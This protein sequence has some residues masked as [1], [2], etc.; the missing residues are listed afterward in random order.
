MEITLY[1]KKILGGILSG[2]VNPSSIDLD[3]ADMPDF[4]NA[5]RIC[6]E[7]DVVSPDL[8]AMKLVE[9]YPDDSFYTA[10]DFRIFAQS[11]P[12]AAVVFEA[13]DKV[14]GAA[15]KGYL[16]KALAEIL[17]DEDKSGAAIL[18]GLKAT[19]A[20]A[21]KDYKSLENNFLLMKD[22][23]PKLEAVLRDFHA[24]VSYAVPS[25]FPLLDHMLL[26]GFSKGDLH[27]IVGMTG[28]GKSALALNCAKYQA[29]SGIFVGIVSREMSDVE[30]AMR[31]Q[32]SWQQI[33]RWQ[34]KK[35]IYDATYQELKAGME[36]LAA[37]PIAFDVRT[38]DIEGLSVQA[39]RMVEQYEMKILYVD[40]LQLVGSGRKGNRAEEVAAVSRGLKLVA[41][42]NNI[43]VVALSQFN[44]GAMNADV[45]DL[46]GH[47]KESSG[48]EQ[49]AS[50][51][52]YIQIDNSNPDAK[53][54]PAK[55][56]ILKNRNGT[57]FK[58]IMLDYQG[59][60]FTFTEASYQ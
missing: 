32:S 18:D 36:Q 10:D 24:G 34:M 12:S 41:M 60:T 42:E 49:D 1:E 25:G 35:G 55:V 27:I 54:K 19:I 20:K 22:I 16:K 39:K 30:N 47:L 37:L 31:I 17:T 46:L 13:V 52:S 3:P 33:P 28:H 45:M 57:T 44:R 2:A 9:R 26:D 53:F 14:K 59:E 56:Q 43:P 21:D 23:V 6:K 38:N 7:L 40:Y 58:P 11:A 8:L 5:L 48:I 50:T 15:L 4:G 29:M 51:I